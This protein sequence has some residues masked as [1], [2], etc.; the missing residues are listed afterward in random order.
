VAM[1]SWI[2]VDVAENAWIFDAKQG[3][4]MYNSHVLGDV[5]ENI[6]VFYRMC[7]KT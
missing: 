7:T 2:Q 1:E 4:I 3:S 6:T 5:T